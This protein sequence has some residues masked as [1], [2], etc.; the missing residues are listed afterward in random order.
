M[1]FIAPI[2]G[3][4]SRVVAGAVLR[5]AGSRVLGTFARVVRLVGMASDNDRVVVIR[6]SSN[7][8]DAGRWFGDHAKQVEWATIEALTKTAKRLKPIMTSEVDRI[9]DKPVEF[10][11][12]AFGF[13]P[14][15]RE[16][17]YADF[18]VKRRQAKYLLPN[19]VGGGRR[20][21]PFERGLAT[22][23]GVDAYWAPGKG[24][25]LTAA[26]NLE[27]EHIEAIARRLKKTGK[28]SD[29]FVGQPL[30]RSGLPFGIWGRELNG[31]G[32]TPLL[33]RIE[34][35]RYKDVFRFYDIAQ[36]EVPRIFREEF[37]RSFQK[38]IRDIKPISKNLETHAVWR[39]KV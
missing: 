25:R 26:G 24:T 7:M 16:K 22:D 19:I 6:V 18:F 36:R 1:W 29:V 20:Q 39:R 9:F 35:P 8:T 37:N 3:Q 15:T 17:P 12:K 31:T 33:I 34:K 14:A 21:K 23:T 5:S 27:K 10:T 28:F 38:A 11:R 2:A 32:I 13:A 30:G 4:L